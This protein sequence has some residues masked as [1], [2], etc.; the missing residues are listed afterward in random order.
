MG[1][2]AYLKNDIND[3]LLRH[4]KEVDLC[5]VF[6]NADA[7]EGKMHS[8]GKINGDRNGCGDG[9][10]DTIVVIHAVGPV[11]LERWIDHPRVKAV[12]HAGLPGQE[13]GNALVDVLFGDVDASGRLPYTIG[14]TVE[15]YGPGGQIL[16]Y[17][18]AAVPQQ[19]F[20]E[21]L[22]I[23]YRH[24]DRERIEPR[25]EFGFGLSYTTFEYTDVDI[26]MT[27]S[28]S[29][30]PS[31]RPAALQPPEY[32]SRVP[33]PSTAVYPDGFRRLKKYVYPYIA[34][35][36]EVKAGQY[37][38]P[39]GW[40]DH[41]PPSPAGGAP[42]GN[43]SLFENIT[44]VSFRLR[45]IGDRAGQEVVQLY[46]SFPDNVVDSASGAAVDFPVRVLRGFQKVGLEPGESRLVE[47]DLTRKDLSY[48]SAAQQNWVMP[49]E[50]Q[51]TVSI[52]RS[53]R[54][55]QLIGQI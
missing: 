11:I 38:Y 24:F 23:D 19:N 27:G 32:D 39:A 46:L 2:T 4:M 7:G 50:G 34:N 35:V 14:K 5:M 22:Y 28:K 33:D 13:S 9:K 41:Q 54:D 17:A 12:L 42:G 20:S 26:T 15:D 37:P 40:A 31:A 6:A 21:G 48:W 8:R 29:A 16:Y 25:F 53:S 44:H 49:V 1:T 45:N 10:G 18:N 36:N 43:P 51:F 52:G 47:L 3:Q 30:L 55:V